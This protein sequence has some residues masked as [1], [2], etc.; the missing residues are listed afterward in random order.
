MKRTHTVLGRRALRRPRLLT[1]LLAA[2]TVAIPG[3]GR[4]EVRP[5]VRE[6][7]ANLS[8]LNQIGEGVALDDFDL[9][10]RSAAELEA[11]AKAMLDFDVSLLGVDPERDPIFDDY[12][13]A[14]RQAARAIAKAAKSEDGALV[15]RGVKTLLDDACIACHQNFRDRENLMRP[16]ILFMASLLD[17]WKDL[18]RGM[19]TNDFDLV[20][21]RAH[22]IQAI[23]RVFTWDPVIEATFGLTDPNERSEF[24]VFLRRVTAQARRLERAADDEKA[25]AIVEAARLMWTDGC[26]A[27]HEQFRSS[28]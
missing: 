19:M 13:Q 1:A 5:L 21:R 4:A 8:S 7:L 23:G 10:K 27:C 12:L 11:R 25:D 28:D 6:M 17:A 18:N 22:E 9:V 20:A 15:F 14:Q 16:A 2:A 24:R 3:P 26:L